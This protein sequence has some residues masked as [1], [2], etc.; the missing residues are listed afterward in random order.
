MRKK[1]RF[2]LISIS[3][4]NFKRL[5]ATSASQK[6]ARKNSLQLLTTSLNRLAV[7][8]LPQASAT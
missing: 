3:G 1:E 7:P 5:L 6:L 8:A 4:R 2:V